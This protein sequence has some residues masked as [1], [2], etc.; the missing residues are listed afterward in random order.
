MLAQLKLEGGALL[1]HPILSLFP[2]CVKL[3]REGLGFR[4][5]ILGHFLRHSADAK[6]ASHSGL[7]S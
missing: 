4:E 6:L 3:V 2:G 7:T 1:L 5:E